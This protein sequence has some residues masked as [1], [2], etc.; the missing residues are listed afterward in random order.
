MASISSSSSSQLSIFTT[1]VT[2]SSEMSSV[3]AP[4]LLT[5]FTPP[6]ECSER[7]VL[8]HTID[9]TYTV[10]STRSQSV[11]WRSNSVWSACHPQ[12]VYPSSYSPG[13]CPSGYEMGD[14]TKAIQRHEKGSWTSWNA[15]CC[16]NGLIANRPFS[17]FASCTGHFTK[18]LRAFMPL[19]L[20]DENDSNPRRYNGGYEYE[21]ATKISGTWTSMVNITILTSGSARADGI[22]IEWQA[23]DLSKFPA[24]YARSLAQQLGIPLTPTRSSITSPT[25]SPGT[26]TSLLLPQQTDPPSLPLPPSP[27][28][29]L[30]TGAKAGIGIGAIFSAA[31]VLGIITILVICRHRRKSAA[32]TEQVVSSPV[33]TKGVDAMLAAM[34]KS[35]L[36]G[37]W[38]SEAEDKMEVSELDAR[39]VGLKAPVEM[40]AS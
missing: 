28:P 31:L 3:N 8:Q 18:A 33:A 13:V 4:A 19:T 22:I 14:V 12:S 36:E 32:T 27:P 10:Y 29:N 6:S 11:D 2:A 40:D 25:A 9:T 24:P 1:T 30:S 39:S 34:R 17:G 5:V 37:R 35:D 7:W 38:R 16:Q 21:H 20:V 15:A 23:S 26:W